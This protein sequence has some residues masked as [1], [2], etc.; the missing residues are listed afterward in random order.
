MQHTTPGRVVAWSAGSLALAVVLGVIGYSVGLS[1]ALWKGSLLGLDQIVMA[2]PTEP[3]GVERA[4]ALLFGWPAIVAGVAVVIR[5][6]KHG[7]PVPR[8]IALYFVIPVAAL[9]AATV[10]EVMSIR[11]A[12]GDAT[13]VEPMVTLATLGPGGAEAK[14]GAFV[15]AMIWLW[16][17]TRRPTT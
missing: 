1:L 7:R 12:L 16:V 6:I 10:L 8:S 14:V 5:E 17:T 15:A 13:G 3:R 11:S 4:T 2:S 9:A